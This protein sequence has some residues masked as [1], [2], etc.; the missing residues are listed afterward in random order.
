MF[1]SLNISIISFLQLRLLLLKA[2]TELLV[3]EGGSGFCA[4]GAG[5]GAMASAKRP[6]ESYEDDAENLD[7]AGPSS[8]SHCGVDAKLYR[9]RSSCI[10]G[11]T[12]GGGARRE[13]LSVPVSLSLLRFAIARAQN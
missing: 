13:N 10:R 5:T 2:P 12:K 6:R 4:E 8:R 7:E 1:V 9:R 3:V 11:T